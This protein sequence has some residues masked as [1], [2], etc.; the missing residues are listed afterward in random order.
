[1]A[2]KVQYLGHKNTKEGIESTEDKVILQVL[3]YPN[4]LSGLK[5]LLVLLC[6]IF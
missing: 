4:S 3:P 1:M 6:F 2:H 5:E